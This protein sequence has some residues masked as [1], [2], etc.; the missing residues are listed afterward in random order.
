[1]I[2]VN[3]SRKE[4]IKRIT[5]YAD[6]SSLFE[7]K[8]LILDTTFKIP[9][10]EYKIPYDKD[11]LNSKYVN[12]FMTLTRPPE[13]FLEAKPGSLRNK[14]KILFKTDYY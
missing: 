7:K 5:I 8:G 6:S 11:S 4:K 12:I 9:V 14:S 13:I 3:T 2:I 10:D 1:M